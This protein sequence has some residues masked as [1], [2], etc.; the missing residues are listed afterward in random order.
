M[1]SPL[2]DRPGCWVVW[3]EDL[4]GQYVEVFDDELEAFRAA[5]V[6]GGI[7]HQV[8]WVP[9]GMGVWQALEAEAKENQRNRPLFQTHHR[10]IEA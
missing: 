4:D 1:K 2:S 3:A 5:H 7:S 6:G 8:T 9:F 10:A